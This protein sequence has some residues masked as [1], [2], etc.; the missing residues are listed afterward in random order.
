MFI[1]RSRQDGTTHF[2][3][4][5]PDWTADQ[6]RDHVL[7]PRTDHQ[8]PPGRGSSATGSGPQRQYHSPRAY[9]RLSTRAP[10]ASQVLGHR[11][12]AATVGRI[13]RG[14]NYAT[15]P[16]RPAV[17]Q[18]IASQR[19]AVPCTTLPRR[20]CSPGTHSVAFPVGSNKVLTE[21]T[22]RI[23]DGATAPEGP[24]FVRNTFW[25]LWHGSDRRCASSRDQRR[26]VPPDRTKRLN[27]PFLEGPSKTR[28]TAPSWKGTARSKVG[29]VRAISARTRCLPALELVGAGRIHGGRTKGT[30]DSGP[31]PA[32]EASA[33]T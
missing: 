2:A 17:A 13:V 4:S 24:R 25:R 5:G 32:Q 12:P 22:G 20:P 15:A 18:Q 9:P 1:S 31:G 10:L 11:R 8:R 3:G 19:T 6:G 21:R 30:A 14:R 28:R 23:L 27:K 16:Q 7:P 29:G 33:P 26:A